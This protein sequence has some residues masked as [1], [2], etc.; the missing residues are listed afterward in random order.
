MVFGKVSGLALSR[1]VVN[2]ITFT[3]PWHA[4][5]RLGAY[6]ALPVHSLKQRTSVLRTYF[7]GAAFLSH[8]CQYIFCLRV[9]V[10]A[11]HGVYDGVHKAARFI[12]V[13]SVFVLDVFH[14]F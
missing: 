3:A 9:V 13:R 7:P 5:V 8:F 4:R 12:V 1:A 2:L 11:R 14:K 6:M 10:S